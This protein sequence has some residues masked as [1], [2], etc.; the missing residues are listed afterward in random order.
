MA[1]SAM[2]AQPVFTLVLLHGAASNSTRWW[3]Y[4]RHTRLGPQWKLLRPDLRGHAGG[5]DRGRI[6]MREWCDDIAALLDAEGRERAVLCGHSLGA[7]VALHFAARRPERVSALVLVEPVPREALVGWVWRVA[8]LRPIASGLALAVRAVNALGLRR[9]KLEPM[10]LEKWDLALQRGEGELSRY[11]SPISD[12][13][14]TPLAAYLQTFAALVEPLPDLAR[15]AAPALVLLSAGRSLTDPARSR[16]AMER[17][18]RA[19][20]V[21]IEATHWIPAEQ[22]DAMRAA[23]D[24]WLTARETES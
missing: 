14:S 20:I 6:G 16:A 13:R 4:A 11:A 1:D 12:L 7:N 9:R 2:A 18:P 5:D 8:P 15:I 24:G 17:L 3:H 19:E 23:I 10:N 22:P 21:T